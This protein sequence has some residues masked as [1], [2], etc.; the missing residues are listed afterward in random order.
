MTIT[1]LPTRPDDMA[2]VSLTELAGAYTHNMLAA[3]TGGKR[4][5][6]A[7]LVNGTAITQRI[8]ADRWATVVAAL[9]GGTTVDGVAEAMSL[10]LDGV[11][12]GLTMWA[13][14]QHGEGSI[15]E[16]RCE[17]ILS[18]IRETVDLNDEQPRPD[19]AAHAGRMDQE[20]ADRVRED[21]ANGQAS[22]NG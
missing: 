2:D 19:W 6:L 21:V 1:G 13:V 9:T 17:E 12:I 8:D 14:D 5:A 10:G 18:L 7:V 4:S 20:R 15:S 22:S 3:V 11:R 16:T